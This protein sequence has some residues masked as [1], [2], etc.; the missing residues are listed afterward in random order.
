MELL[1]FDILFFLQDNFS[2]ALA[3]QQTLMGGQPR[4]YSG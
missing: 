1:I 2:L 3:K 4:V